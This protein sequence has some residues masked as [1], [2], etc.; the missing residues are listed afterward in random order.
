M[1]EGFADLPCVMLQSTELATSYSLQ[2]M[3]S[4]GYRK[5]RMGEQCLVVDLH[6]PSSP[7]ISPI[8]CMKMHGYK[9]LQESVMC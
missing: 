3:H 6:A 4:G 9:K 8:H 1:S 2:A 7:T 5:N